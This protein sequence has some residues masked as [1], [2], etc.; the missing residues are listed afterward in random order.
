MTT[1]IPIP[2][3]DELVSL[4]HEPGQS[5]TKLG[6]RY[7]VSGKTVKKWLVRYDVEL[8]GYQEVR[9]EANALIY[10]EN[11]LDDKTLAFLSDH[12]WLYDQRIV[13]RKPYTS[14]ADEL[15]VCLS[16]ITKW[17]KKHQIADDS[18]VMYEKV[19]IQLFWMQIKA[20]QNNNPKALRMIAN[21]IMDRYDNSNYIF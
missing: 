20:A 7:N 16:T 2:P 12:D 21:R 19:A 15:G 10:K 8:K 11:K 1:P 9:K 14:I 3:R 4:Y 5:M 13:Q 17:I 18:R 6:L